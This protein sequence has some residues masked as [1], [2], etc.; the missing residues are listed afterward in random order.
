MQTLKKFMKFSL[1][2][3]SFILNGYITFCKQ[4]SYNLFKIISFSYLHN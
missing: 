1:S 4:M 2:L 3:N